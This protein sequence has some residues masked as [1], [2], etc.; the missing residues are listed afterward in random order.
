MFKKTTQSIISFLDTSPYIRRFIRII[1]K[2]VKIKIDIPLKLGKDT[3]YV[4]SINRCIAKTLWE[5]AC[6]SD[7][8]PELCK[9]T[10]KKGMTVLDIGA[11]IGFFTMLFAKLVGKEGKVFAFEPDPN[12]FRLLKKN[13]ET[14]KYTNVVCVN[15]AVSNKTAPGT[16]FISEEHHGDHRIFDPNDKRTSIDIQ[17]ISIDDF[18]KEDTTVDFIKIDIQGAEYLAFEGMEKTLKKAQHISIISEFCPALLKKA[19]T[20]PMELLTKIKNLGFNIKYLDEDKN[21]IE[22]ASLSDIIEKCHNEKYV[23]LYFEK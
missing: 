14:N 8:E 22:Q 20:D 19:Q 4:N 16:L 12:N 15:K 11:N 3:I 10:I 6:M 13:I 7:L 5:S 17:T 2:T 21:S 23:N 1:L 9:K 18:I